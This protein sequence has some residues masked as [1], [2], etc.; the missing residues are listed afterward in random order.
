M[1]MTQSRWG[2][3]REPT[4]LPPTSVQTPETEGIP[5]RKTCQVPVGQLQI[6][7]ALAAYGQVNLRKKKKIKI[8]DASNAGP[9][10]NWFLYKLH[11]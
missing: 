10:A 3:N 1:P 11:A 5:Y 9:H 7:A 8:L 2:L 4:K 6:Q